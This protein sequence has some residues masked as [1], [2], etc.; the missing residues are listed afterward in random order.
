MQVGTPWLRRTALR[1]APNERRR[2]PMSTRNRAT[3]RPIP[4]PP[5]R[6]TL[7][8]WVEHA[9]TLPGE[10][11]L[12]SLPTKSLP[13]PETA[14]PASQWRGKLWPSGQKL[15]KYVYEWY[16]VGREPGAHQLRRSRGGQTELSAQF[17]SRIHTSGVRGGS[18]GVHQAGG[19][20]RSLANLSS[21]RLTKCRN[22]VHPIVIVRDAHCSSSPG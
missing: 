7:A 14:L 4:Q 8:A 12:R 21:M 9:P 19:E 11:T 3:T 17:Q 1:A 5:E 2:G 13:V 15:R 6:P 20:T 22:S 16:F 18:V 10:Q